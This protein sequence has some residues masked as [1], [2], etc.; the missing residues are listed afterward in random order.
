VANPYL[1]PVARLVRDEPAEMT[2]QFVAPFDGAGE[3]APRGPFESDVAATADVTVD[4]RIESYA[5]GLRARGT[6]RAPWHGVCRR[7]SKEIDGELVIPVA[8]RFVADPTDDDDAYAVDGDVVDLLPLVHD[9]VL[10]ELPIAPL[11]AMECR[12]LCPS[13]GVDRNTATCTCAPESDP[14][15][16]TLDALRIDARP[17]SEGADEPQTKR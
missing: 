7:C 13:C 14:R 9:A 2:T 5:G 1:V 11:C 6:V 8:E 17:L 3:F 12:G 10:L 16:A 15:W 4:L